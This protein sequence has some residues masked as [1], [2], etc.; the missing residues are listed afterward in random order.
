MARVKKDLVTEGEFWVTDPDTGLRRKEVLTRARFAK[1]LESFDKLRAKGYNVPAPF[2]HVDKNGNLPEPVRFG[3]HGAPKALENGGFLETLTQE[4]RDA[5][6]GKSIAVLV[7]EI[8]VPGDENDPA[9]N[10]YKVGRTVKDTSVY[11]RPGYLDGTGEVHEEGFMHV[12]MVVNPIQPGLANFQHVKGDRGMAIAMSQMIMSGPG[13]TPGALSAQFDEQDDDENPDEPGDT[14]GDP[15]GQ[16][17]GDL[18]RRVV[19]ALRQ[20]KIMDLPDDTDEAMI[21]KYILVAVRQKQLMPGP[22]GG[23]VPPGQQTPPAPPAGAAPGAVPPG[24]P[25]AASPPIPGQADAGAQAAPGQAPGQSEPP[26]P[27]QPPVNLKKPPKAGVEQP[28]SIAMSQQTEQERALLMSQ[29]GNLEASNKLLASYVTN[30]EAEKRSIRIANLVSSGRVTQ[31]YADTHL[32]PALQGFTMSLNAEGKLNPNS[33]DMTLGALEAQPARTG[34]VINTLSSIDL[35]SIPVE[36]QAAVA[37]IL[38]SMGG[39]NMPHGATE[40]GHP[41]GDSF[42]ARPGQQTEAEAIATADQ[43]LANVK[44]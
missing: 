14:L 24:Q 3:R 25:G 39:A 32:K 11:V 26:V 34:S 1:W 35:G 13:S 10:A 15:S 16:I 33:I 44:G 40:Q 36:S 17:S 8:E 29:V 19:E 22:S 9:T 42:F 41:G 7:G 2:D 43:F 30:L 6:D 37:S 38:M 4:I 31:A 28:P 23:F 21:L 18:T 12:A 20:A 27:G 5:G